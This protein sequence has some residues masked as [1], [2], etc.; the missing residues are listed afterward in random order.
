[1]MAG[2]QGVI[3]HLGVVWCVNNGSG[4]E[5]KWTSVSPCYKVARLASRF[6]GRGWKAG[7][8]TRPHFG[9]T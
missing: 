6:H 7:A 5:E 1:M 4:L 9:S 8:Y 2:L 3:R